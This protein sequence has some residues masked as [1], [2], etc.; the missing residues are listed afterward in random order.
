MNE[1]EIRD[2]L[3]SSL[4]G[5]EVSV[6][7]D[8]YHIDITVVSDVF[9]GQSRV[10]RQQT[11]YGALGDAIRSGAIHAVNIKAITPAERN[12]GQP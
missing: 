8:G 4:P 11:V 3:E 2:L 12:G 7:G 5:A 6:G 10:R 1:V 9:A